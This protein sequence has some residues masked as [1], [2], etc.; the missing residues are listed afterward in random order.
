MKQPKK[1]NLKEAKKLAVK[2]LEVQ[3]IAALQ[4]VAGGFEKN[5]K[6]IDV[7]ITKNAKQLAKKIAK[8]ATLVLPVAKSEQ[9]FIPKS[10]KTAVTNTEKSG[11][12]KTVKPKKASLTN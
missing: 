5:Q 10:E 6:K 11:N 2:N 4:T 8:Q 7:L 12:T 3:F 9:A 1:A